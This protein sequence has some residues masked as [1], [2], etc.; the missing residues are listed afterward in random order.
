MT[1]VVSDLRKRFGQVVALDG[2][3]FEAPR[4]HVF[5]F[6]GAHGAG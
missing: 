6:L 4:G 2:L 3:S 1:L 5:G